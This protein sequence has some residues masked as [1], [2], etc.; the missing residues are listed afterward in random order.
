MRVVQKFHQPFCDAVLA[1]GTQHVD[2]DVPHVLRSSRN[3]AA[4]VLF[5]MCP[6]VADAI[7]ACVTNES[8]ATSPVR[9][10]RDWHGRCGVWLQ[11]QFG[12][13]DL[14]PG[15]YLVHGEPRACP[16]CIGM[17]V[18]DAQNVTFWGPG[19]QWQSTEAAVRKAAADALDRK[20]LVVFRVAYSAPEPMPDSALLGSEDI[21]LDLEAGDN[22]IE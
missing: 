20:V 17:R 2:F 12:I 3:T 16:T 13:G 14:S 9:P 10:Y 4:A 5:K 1:S 7:L 22:G 11:P 19:I 6:Q 21:L 15:S 8:P 18:M